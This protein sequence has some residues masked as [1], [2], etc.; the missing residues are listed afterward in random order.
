MKE[1]VA[2]VRPERREATLEAMRQA[3]I[4]EALHVRVMGR[5][6]QQGLQY[7]RRAQGEQEAGMAFLSKRLV[8]WLVPDDQVAETVRTLIR[9]NQ[10][11]NHGD[12]KIFVCPVDEA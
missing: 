5:G 9:V 12:G 2:V 6:R 7:L 4:P 1:V 8:V 11:G 3:G 10:S